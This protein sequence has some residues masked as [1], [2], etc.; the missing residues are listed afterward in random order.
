VNFFTSELPSILLL[1]AVGIV[2]GAA[3]TK[4]LSKNSKSAELQLKLEEAEERYKSY[5]QEV[6]EHFQKTASLVN[7]LTESYREVHTHL[8]TG[9]QTLAKDNAGALEGTAFKALEKDDHTSK[10]KE[11]AMEQKPS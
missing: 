6:A 4:I 7:N 8:A 1:I 11:E 9:A 10:I 2:I 5:Q 3:L